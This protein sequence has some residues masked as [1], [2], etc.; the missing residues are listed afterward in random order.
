M[1]NRAFVTSSKSN[2][3]TQGDALSMQN[4]ALSTNPN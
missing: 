2:L 3:N 4:R 1:G